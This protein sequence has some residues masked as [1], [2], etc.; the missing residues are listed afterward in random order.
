MATELYKPPTALLA[1]AI[2]GAL[3]LVALASIALAQYA[4]F[5]MQA[6]LEHKVLTRPSPELL[7]LRQR[8]AARLSSYQWVDRKAGIVR[9]PVER[10]L[11]LTVHEW[12][13][14]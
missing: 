2:L 13:A 6:E 1:V 14:P 10:A 4:G 12:R 9:I 3:L 11:M 8:E 5:A 7:A